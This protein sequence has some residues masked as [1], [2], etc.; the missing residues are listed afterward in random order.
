MTD[1]TYMKPFSEYYVSSGAKV[2]RYFVST[3]SG[4]G[5]KKIFQPERTNETG[6]ASVSC[7]FIIY[8]N[9]KT[10]LVTGQM[11]NAKKHYF[12]KMIY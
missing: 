11:N 5:S 10:P 4:R 6:L 1:K 7:N 9:K 8:T 2:V 12:T 3:L